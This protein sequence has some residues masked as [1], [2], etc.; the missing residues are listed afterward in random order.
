[1]AATSPEALV[2]S[3]AT[4]AARADRG[5]VDALTG[6]RGFAA[7][8]VVAV[9]ASGL[10]D[11][12]WF[13]LHTY[14]P[15][16]LFALS[17]FL[18]FQPW[19]AWLLGRRARPSLSQYTKRRLYRIFPAWI[20]ALIIVALIYPPS[21][22]VGIK[23]WL[24]SLSLTQTASPTG[25][26]PGLEQAWSLGT[27]LTWYV[28]VPLLGAAAGLA[29]KRFGVRPLYAVGGLVFLALLVTAAWRY[30]LAYHWTDLGT[31]LTRPYWLPAYLVCFVGGAGL[32]HIMLSGQGPG[33]GRRPVQWISDQPWLVIGVA[34]ATGAIA[35][36]RLGGGWGWVAHTTAE[37][38]IRFVFTTAL[39]LVLLAA[40]AAPRRDTMITAIFASRP[41]VAIGRWSYSLYLW[42][43]PIRDVLRQ[44]IETPSGVAGLVLWLG[45]LLAISVPISAASY[46]FVERPAIAFSRRA[47]RN[48]QVAQQP[49]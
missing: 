8:V 34:V 39:A 33:A 18:L 47:R 1:M 2:A 35:N 30:Q 6:Y 13:G 14:G 22:P 44:H 7:L 23:G 49:S 17:G 36:S 12:P 21:R 29:V 19:S 27:E 41:M 38:T 48:R 9:H 5:H 4:T 31:L 20:V 46:A 24:L 10:T 40:I 43:L 45:L 15:I 16:A 11:F 32:A 26:R 37:T 3:P 25:L 28:A 42:H